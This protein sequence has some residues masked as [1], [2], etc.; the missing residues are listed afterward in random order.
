[1]SKA[2]FNDHEPFKVQLASL[3]DGKNF[4]A[5]VFPDGEHAKFEILSD[6]DHLSA[7]ALRNLITGLI[8]TMRQKGVDYKIYYEVPTDNEALALALTGNKFE[9]HDSTE[10]FDNYSLIEGMYRE[11]VA[12]LGVVEFVP[13]LAE[14]IETIL[15]NEAARETHA[16]TEFKLHY[17]DDSEFDSFEVSAST[18]YEGTWPI[19]RLIIKLKGRS[20]SVTKTRK[21][22]EVIELHIDPITGKVISYNKNIQYLDEK[23][24]EVTLPNVGNGPYMLEIDAQEDD[25]YIIH[26]LAA[27]DSLTHLAP[28]LS[29][30]QYEEITKYMEKVLVEYSVD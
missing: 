7:K 8:E 1:M 23:N 18:Y 21:P 25:I 30:E 12:S 15:S 2:S 27:Q 6:I 20:E 10:E 26:P 16:Q 14:T 3:E 13:E 17:T 22:T 9:K 28:G 29:H 24:K 11:H 5:G 19:Y 4:E